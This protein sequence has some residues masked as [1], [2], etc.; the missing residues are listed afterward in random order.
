MSIENDVAAE[1]ASELASLQAEQG[2][3]PEEAAPGADSV[4]G[5]PE[6]GEAPEGEE[7]E[8]DELE[9]EPEAVADEAGIDEIRELIDAGDLRAAAEKLGLAPSIFKLNNRQ[10]KAAR[11]AAREAKTLKAEAETKLTSASDAVTKAE[12]LNAKAEEIYGPVVAGKFHY[13]G[14]P[15]RG[16]PP[17]PMKARAA[18]ELLF[19]DSFENIF[20][21]LQKAAK[22]IDPAQFEVLKLRKELADEKARKET[23]TAA[24]TAAQ[25]DATELAGIAAKLKGTPLE[26]LSSE[27]AADIQKVMRAS[28]NKGLGRY[29]KTL[30]EAYAE[31]KTDYAAK[32]AKLAAVTG[33]RPGA[34]PK[35]EDTRKPLT[36][37]RNPPKAG[38]LTEEQEF[39]A[40]LKAAKAATQAAERKA[41]R[42]AR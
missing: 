39:Q 37:P 11:T 4:E 17:D 5:D 10:F 26:T 38:K 33:K 42:G 8:A 13:K 41:R 1:L 40:E 19:E 24:A 3:E 36:P 15:S 27:A 21:N 14:D 9:E 29:T 2:S 6:V 30:K 25:A 12:T 22:G 28:Y 16:I 31:V 18:M 7:E 35:V 23:E 34:K 32:A 20:T